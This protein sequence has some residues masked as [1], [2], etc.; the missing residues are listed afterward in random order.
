MNIRL[1]EIT[2]EA[3]AAMATLAAVIVALIPICE[4]RRQKAHARGLRVRLCSKLTLLR[5]SLAKVVQ[6]GQANYPTAILSKEE[7]REVVHSIGT[8][9][10]ESSV[11]EPDEQDRIGL[12][13]ANLQMAAGLYA[14]PDLI[15]DS[16]KNVLALIDGAISVMEKRGLLHRPVEAPWESNAKGQSSQAG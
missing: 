9:L 11:L 4:A 16:A 13:F 1:S 7:F 15:E 3:I 6:R 10:Q 5:P 14:T 12:V 8:M 2:W